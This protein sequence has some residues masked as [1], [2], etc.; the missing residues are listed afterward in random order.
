MVT[1]AAGFIGRHVVAALCD[2]GHRVLALDVSPESVDPRADFIQADMRQAA[3][4]LDRYGLPDACLHLAWRD[5]FRH[6]SPAH[7]EELSDHFRFVRLIAERGIPKLT[8]LGTMHEVG[9]WEGPVTED[10]PCNPR[11]LYGIAKN[12]LR[13]SAFA[14]AGETGALSWIRA[15]Y[16]TGDDARNKSIFS[17][18]IAAERAGEP[19]FPLNSGNN[20]YDFIDVDAL[21]RQI[22]MVGT[23]PSA[24]GIIN[25]CSGNPVSLR[26][27]VEAF[28]AE[29]GFRIRPVY[30]A[31]PDRPYD[32]PGIWGDAARITEIMQAQT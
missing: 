19:N 4:V 27:K 31:Y 14:V 17:K 13:R 28:I 7:M 8:V 11:T 3:G 18:I 15:F 5:G 25:C 30:G 1:G 22:A 20:R 9:Y 16:V 10:T 23:D 26:D 6:D 29:N 12:A 32:S 2:R 24:S 21:A